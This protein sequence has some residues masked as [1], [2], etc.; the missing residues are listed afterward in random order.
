[1]TVGAET[2]PSRFRPEQSGA[3]PDAPK[4][5]L[6]GFEQSGHRGDRTTF[7]QTETLP[8]AKKA[9]RTVTELPKFGNRQHLCLELARL[10][11]STHLY[12]LRFL[13]YSITCS[14]L[15]HRNARHG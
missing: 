3:A 7:R 4:F 5:S 1:M 10:P 6:R 14:E 8:E 9:P 13:T 12:F 15:S 2:T 11:Q